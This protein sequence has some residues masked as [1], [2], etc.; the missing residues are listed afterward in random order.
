MFH[1]PAH[2]NAAN[3]GAIVHPK[4][5]AERVLE[6]RVTLHH[7]TGDTV[8]TTFRSVAAAMD[9]ARSYVTD[10]YRVSIEQDFA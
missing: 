6:F 5:A 7:K 4:A 1:I 10:G 3:P 9:L 8:T 2:K